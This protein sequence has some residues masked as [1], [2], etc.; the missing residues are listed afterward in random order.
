MP[1]SEL[2]DAKTVLL[3]ALAL[4]GV[5]Y[6][7]FLV[8]GMRR[9]RRAAKVSA[10]AT[11][12]AAPTPGGVATGFITNFFDTLGIGSYAPT[13]AI[14]RFWKL[15]PDEQIPGTMNVG[16]TLPT[17]VQAFIFTRLVPVDAR[18]LI[19]MIAA[20]IAGAWLGAGVVASWPRRTIQL[21]MGLALTCAATLMLVSQFHLTPT[22]GDALALSGGKLVIAVGVNFI[23]GA[24]MTLGIG[25]YAPC[26]ILISLLG[27][28]PTAAFPIMMGSCAF[29]MPVA[30]A[31]FIRRGAFDPR[32][33]MG[34]LI[35]GIPAVLIAAFIV[36]S[37]PLT[38]V[39]WLV[40]VVVL[41]TAATLLRSAMRER[42]APRPPLVTT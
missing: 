34:L 29:L 25:L 16:H 15:V 37:L 22:A 30:S 11:N 2:G 24:L 38:A 13:T 7:G 27:M 6:F 28:N 31:R 12:P 21:G 42:A 33:V 41:Y 4:F 39:R 3:V 14:F 9:A 23:L 32:A 10:S 20:A 5:G 35:G 19:L 26:L 36:K 1:A 18:T 8:Y 17:I 40:I